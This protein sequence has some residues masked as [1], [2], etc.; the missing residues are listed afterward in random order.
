MILLTFLSLF[1]AGGLASC[2]DTSAIKLKSEYTK[3]SWADREDGFV[4]QFDELTKIGGHKISDI[5]FAKS[6]ED[7]TIEKI[8]GEGD[9]Y[10][11]YKW[12]AICMSAGSFAVSASIDNLTSNELIFTVDEG[13]LFNMDCS[14]PN[15]YQIQYTHMFYHPDNNTY[16]DFNVTK[17]NDCFMLIYSDP[18]G[19]RFFEKTNKGYDVYYYSEGKW[20]LTSK[21]Y[22]DESGV[23]EFMLRH[24]YPNSSTKTE[25]YVKKTNR[26]KTIDGKVYAVTSLEYCY[27]DTNVYYNYYS[28]ADG[29]KLSLRTNIYGDTEQDIIE[30]C[31][32]YKIDR[33]SQFP[34]NPPSA[35]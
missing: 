27:D 11:S 33:V 26:T 12:K 19:N 14:V 2:G 25:E 24:L 3:L 10:L 8:F 32:V 7:V 28:G 6:K 13:R 17:L 29:L 1:M 4:F 31:N 22:C 20:V 15:G 34:V 16:K 35:E 21:A 18:K 23:L 9:D 5:T 30:N